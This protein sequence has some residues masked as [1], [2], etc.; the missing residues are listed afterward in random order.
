MALNLC[1]SDGIIRLATHIA[2]TVTLVVA[3]KPR[4][5]M[6]APLSVD[7]SF[8]ETYDEKVR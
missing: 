3:G 8:M 7:E 5:L 6:L 1:D 4:L 2:T